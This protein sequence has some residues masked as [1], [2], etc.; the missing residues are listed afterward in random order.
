MAVVN[1]KKCKS[2]VSTTSKTCPVCGKPI[3]EPIH[4]WI[5]VAAI[6]GIL[7]LIGSGSIDNKRTKPSYK[8]SDVSYEEIKAVVEDSSLTTAQLENKLSRYNGIYIKWTG[9]VFEAKQGLT[10]KHEIWV[11][12]DGNLQDVILNTTEEILLS[13]NKG[14][15]ITFVGKITK[16]D[17]FFGVWVYV[18][19][20]MIR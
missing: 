6:I 20:D 14:E 5:I 4:R 3:K 2:Q 9:R 18:D 1:C 7:Y 17:R 16:V 13:V 10:K 15:E 8:I 12:M 19:L 11:D